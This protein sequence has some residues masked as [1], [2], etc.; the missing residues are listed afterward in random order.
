[1]KAKSDLNGNVETPAE[2]AGDGPI[3]DVNGDPVDAIWAAEFRGFFWG[4]G[5]IAVQIQNYERHYRSISVSAS[6]GLRTDDAA[7]LREFQRRLGG[8]LK[9]ESYRDGSGRTVTRWK[10]GVAAHN[11]RIAHLLESP[12][13]LPFNKAKQLALWR[14]AIETKLQSGATSGSRYTPEARATMVRVSAELQK[15]RT[16]AG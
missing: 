6:I 11:L 7:V 10:T 4:E 14:L 2:M 8:T 13:G 16:W 3:L 1:M 12:T 15:L 5:T 9:I